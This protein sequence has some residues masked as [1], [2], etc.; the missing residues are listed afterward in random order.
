MTS[1]VL[2]VLH[3][4]PSMAKRYGGPSTV[5]YP[6]TSA[7]NR[8]CDVESVIATTDADG[9]RRSFDPTKSHSGVIVHA[10]PRTISEQW[11]Y[12]PA[13]GRWLRAHVR[14]FDIVQIHSVWSYSTCAA[15]AA[16]RQCGVPYVLMPCGMF[17]DYC[18]ATRRLKKWLY[19]HAIER[20]TIRHA[21]AF[22]CT[23]EDEVSDVLKLRPTANTFIIPHGI[24]PSAFAAPRDTNELRRRCGPAAADRP[25]V[26]FLG[27]LHPVKGIIDHLIPAFTRMRSNAFLAIAG[28]ADAGYPDHPARIRD[29]IARL[30]LSDRI[31]LLGAV[32]SADRW[33]LFDGATAFVLPSHSE[34][35]GMVVAE[36]M[37]RA[38]PVVVTQ[39]VQSKAIVLEAGAGAVVPPH[40]DE[41]AA[42]LD[43]LVTDPIAASAAGKAGQEYVRTRLTWDSVAARISTIYRKICLRAPRTERHGI[44]TA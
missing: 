22:Y 21:A 13:L 2:R 18:L 20:N 26:L 7:L 11:K 42:A 17:S 9:P 35:F 38:C 36:A 25:I 23:G 12:S 6:L 33:S 5:V 16:A 24:E 28:G 3:V 19:W 30:G 27:R 8:L 10:F 40:P 44:P 34:N 29:T 15:V 31:A 14:E 32:E 4:I 39:G 41:I 1:G 43:L 37:A